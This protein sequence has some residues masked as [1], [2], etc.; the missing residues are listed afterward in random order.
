M[1]LAFPGQS[2]P[3]W[4]IMARDAFLESLGD[5]AL[6]LRVLERDPETLEQALKLASR[7]EA[8]RQSELEDN[9]DNIGR[10]KDRFV[11]S[12]STDKASVMTALMQEIMVERTGRSGNVC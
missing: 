9:W 2:G 8:L 6:R 1:D 7:L 11:R 5:P 12:S 10:R 4:E 3:L